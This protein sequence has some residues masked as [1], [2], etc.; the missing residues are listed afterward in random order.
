[1][2]SLR[3]SHCARTLAAASCLAALTFAPTALADVAPENECGAGTSVGTACT[4]A[5]PDFNEDGTC[6]SE[7]CHGLGNPFAD[8]SPPSYPCLL[9]ELV[10]A[11]PPEDS[12]S[13]TADDAGPTQPPDAGPPTTNDAG[14]PDG[15]HPT[16]TDAGS[17]TASDAGVSTQLASSSSC[18]VG[19]PGGGQSAG[20]LFALGTIGIALS[21]AS[22]RRKA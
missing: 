9:C 10:D 5:G 13:P 21:A 1:M 16:T 7:T 3:S 11:G 17:S 20:W 6:Q 12:G 8:A 14:L 4:T 15:G 2:I 19:L 18:S 22:R